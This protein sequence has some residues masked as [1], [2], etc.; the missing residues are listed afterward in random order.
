MNPNKNNNNNN[1]NKKIRI[2][3]EK[4]KLVSDRDGEGERKRE[5][6]FFFI[7]SFFFSLFDILS[8]D[9]RNSSSQERKFIYSMRAT[10]DYQKHGISP[11]IQVR[12][13]ENPKFRYFLRSTTF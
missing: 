9:R 4:K 11:R 2:Q 1:N 7:F 6:R 8:F 5:N 10:C 12:S 3:K 13:S